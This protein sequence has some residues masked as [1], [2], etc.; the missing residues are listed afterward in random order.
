MQYTINSRSLNGTTHTP[1][2][3]HTHTRLDTTN[4]D[5]HHHAQHPRR[6]KQL[7]SSSDP[8]TKQSMSSLV[9]AES[10]VWG[11]TT[12]LHTRARDRRPPRLEEST[13]P[14]TP[15][16]YVRRQTVESTKECERLLTRVQDERGLEC[17]PPLRWKFCS[18][19]INCRSISRQSHA[20]IMP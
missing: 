12:H 6:H 1:S 8:M 20:V 2:C 13:T 9:L 17:E 10:R 11:S 4:G 5:N 16:S 19:V 15:S 18:T 3:T 7:L 14:P